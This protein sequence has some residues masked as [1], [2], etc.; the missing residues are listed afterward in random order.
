VLTV[1]DLFDFDGWKITVDFEQPVMVEPVDVVQGGGLDLLDGVPRASRLD[2]LGLVQP[3]HALGQGVV[4]R[5]AY[6]SDRGVD[7]GLGQPL[8]ERDRCVLTAGVAVKPTSA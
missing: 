1:V 7:A 6:R 8:G 2:E 3:D 5:V 4:E